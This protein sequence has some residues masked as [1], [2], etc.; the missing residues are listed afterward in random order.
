MSHIRVL[1]TAIA[2]LSLTGCN[3]SSTD[4]TTAFQTSASQLKPAVCIVPVIDST[5]SQLDW[6]LSDELSS[7]IFDQ[8]TYSNAFSLTNPSKA[9]SITKKLSDQHNPF[10]TETKWVKQAFSGE[11]FV[12]FLELT[13]HEEVLRQERRKL[14]DPENCSADLNIS[15]RIRVFDLRGEEPKVVLQELLH[16]SHFVPRPFTTVNFYQPSWEEENFSISP[17]GLAHNQFTKE[18]ASRLKDYILLARE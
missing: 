13:E 16:D 6:N 7:A 11:D 2:A 18:I 5:K 8:L 1:V 14:S 15:M 3:N 9:R 17:M 4:D 12:V 10:G